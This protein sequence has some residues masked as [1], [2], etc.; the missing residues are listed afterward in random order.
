MGILLE[1]PT[2]IGGLTIVIMIVGLVEEIGKNNVSEK[3]ADKKKTDEKN[4]RP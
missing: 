3:S 4:V 2:I 1:I